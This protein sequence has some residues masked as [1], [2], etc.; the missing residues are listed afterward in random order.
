ML[1]KLS[2]NCCMA[3][4]DLTSA[5]AVGRRLKALRFG[6]GFTQQYIS[7]LLG[8]SS[9]RGQAWQHFEVGNKIL[10]LDA[11]ARMRKLW[12]FLS[13]EWVYEGRGFEDLPGHLRQRIKEGEKKLQGR[14]RVRK[15]P[16]RQGG[17]ELVP[18]T[19]L[20]TYS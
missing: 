16:P 3:E 1:S 5:P 14:A 20:R 4:E 6:Y 10:T 17:L 15:A 9:P 13:Y 7:T 8:Y 18:T 19:P 12:P 2:D 11:F